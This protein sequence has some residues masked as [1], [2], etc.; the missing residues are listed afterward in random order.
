MACGRPIA[1]HEVRIVDEAGV[2][3]P[4]RTEGR[5]Q[6]KGPSATRGYFRNEEKTKALFDGEWLESGDRAYIASGD[7]FITGRI[8]D[9]IIK[10][11]RNIYPHELEELVGGVEGVRKGCVAAFPSTFGG[12]GTERLVLLVETRLTD[13]SKIEA[14]R[15]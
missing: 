14:L 6:F 11:G 4:E 12:A 2:E 1:G 5:L 15:N 9:I 10:A 3:L 8:K 13:P 7:V